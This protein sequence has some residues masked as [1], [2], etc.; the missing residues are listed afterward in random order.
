MKNTIAQSKQ[1]A[2]I[3]Y[4]FFFLF[5]STEAAFAQGPAVKAGE[6]PDLSNTTKPWTRWWW[7]GNAV[8]RKNLKLL[9]EEYKAAGL[10]GLEIAPIYG[11]K[12]HEDRYLE[13]L[14]PEWLGMLHYTIEVADSL[15]LGIDLTQ[16]TGWP[17]GG[18]MV[19]PESAA[20][21]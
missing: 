7:M 1:T 12:G 16:G 18:P 3:I 19:G 14:S 13:Y 20:K 9:L 2:I 21:K 5:L 15:G 11:A 6:W 8:D 4:L 10:G 17:F